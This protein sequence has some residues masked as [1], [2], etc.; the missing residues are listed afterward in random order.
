MSRRSLLT[1]NGLKNQALDGGHQRGTLD[2]SFASTNAAIEKFAVKAEGAMRKE[3]AK[4]FSKSEAERL[5]VPSSEQQLVD[6]VTVDS[7]CNRKSYGVQIA[8][9]NADHV[10]PAPSSRGYRPVR[11]KFWL[12]L[13]RH[14]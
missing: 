8:I 3:E 14:T 9:D 2:A 13:G 7:D 10:P 4:G 12:Q 5:D 6:C 11:V 1:R